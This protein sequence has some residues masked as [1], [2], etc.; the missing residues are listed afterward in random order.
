MAARARRVR[1][2]TRFIT[3]R[4]WARHFS[5][6]AAELLL[7]AFATINT[8]HSHV[9]V[10]YAL[11]T[12]VSRANSLPISLH[13]WALHFSL[14]F[15][16]IRLCAEILCGDEEALLSLRV[17]RT[18]RWRAPLPR[19][20]RYA[21]IM[22]LTSTYILTLR[23]SLEWIHFILAKFHLEPDI[24]SL[25]PEHCAPRFTG[26]RLYV[27]MPQILAFSL[28]IYDD[29]KLMYARRPFP[30]CRKHLYIIIPSL[31][32]RIWDII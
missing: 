14:L 13:V 24:F 17:R 7:R 8:R 18:G 6:N 4:I 10:I 3:C 20:L 32:S 2:A 19:P 5:P 25:S 27:L 16:F 15:L 22:I 28:F 23:I 26:R 9:D 12:W 21:A 11:Y 29:E 30:T 31:L 1:R